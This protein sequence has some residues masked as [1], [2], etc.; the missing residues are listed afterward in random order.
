MY[1]FIKF[2]ELSRKNA[3]NLQSLFQAQEDGCCGMVLNT[4]SELQVEIPGQGL[5][6]V[7]VGQRS[8]AFD[9]E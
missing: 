6:F 5:V 7:G 9:H 8:V 2:L 3:P 4:I 1:K